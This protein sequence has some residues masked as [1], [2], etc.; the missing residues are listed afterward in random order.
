MRRVFVVVALLLALALPV[1]AA[2]TFQLTLL[3]TNDL[4]G[5]MRSFDYAREGG[6]FSG[7]HPNAGG[8][9]RRATLIAQIRRETKHPV[10]VVD[11]GDVFAD[12]PWST[13]LYGTAEIDAM[14]QIGYDL[15]GVGNNEFQATGGPDA[16]DKML[17]LIRRSRFPWLAANLTTEGGGPVEGVRPF[18]VR[19]F[20]DLR[21]AFLGLVPGRVAEYDWIKG[22]KTQDPIAAALHWV[23]I[24]REE[25]DLVIA[26]VHLGPGTARELLAK[27]PGIDA[28]IGGDSHTFTPEVVMMKSADGRDVPYAQAGEKGVVLGRFDLTFEHGSDWHLTAANETLLPITSAIPEDRGVRKLLEHLLDTP[29]TP[30]P[31]GQWR[32][33]PALLSS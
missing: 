15:F 21:V 20:G 24:A 3:H 17:L 11:C 23:P 6:P 8:M 1:C 9:A 28:M 22:W 18:V 25:A 10:L 4:H 14:N 16:Q 32:W 13:K 7:A 2:D 5:M 33:A 31:V 29:A 30:V 19:T 26:V 27:V 12:G